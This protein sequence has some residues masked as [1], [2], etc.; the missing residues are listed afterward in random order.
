MDLNFE[1]LISCGIKRLTRPKFKH[2]YVQLN[3][4]HIFTYDPAAPDS[5]DVDLQWKNYG[6]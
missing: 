5:E 4:P 2:D 6:T 1:K 3:D